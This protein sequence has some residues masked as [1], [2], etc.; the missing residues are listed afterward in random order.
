MLRLR[1]GDSR[2]LTISNLTDED[3]NP[4]IFLAGDVVR[5]TLKRKYEDPDEEAIISKTSATGGVT[6][7]IGSDSGTVLIA[8][9]DWDAFVV[10]PRPVNAV[11]DLELTRGTAVTTLDAGDVL[12]RPDATQT[13]V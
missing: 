12:I 7:V 9:S 4:T 13:A 2:T 11:F 3:G 10:V 1:R 8:A 6:F 5:F